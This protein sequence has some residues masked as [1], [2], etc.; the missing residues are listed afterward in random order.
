MTLLPLL[1]P[2]LDAR[3]VETK[4]AAIMK[5]MTLEEKIGQLVQFP[6][7]SA[8]GPEGARVDQNALIAR[9]GMGS[10]LNATGAAA[11][12]ALQR[13]AVENSRLKIPLLFGFDVIHGYRT[14]FPV[15]L[16]L[17][18]TWD[19]DLIERTARAAAVESTAEGVRWTFSPMVDV[20]RDARW[21]RILEG[22]G[23]DTWLGEK[24]AAAYVRGYQGNSL[25]D[26]TSMIAC[27]KHYAAYGGAEAGRDYNT[28]DL[29]DRVLRQTYLPP[30]KAA[31]DAGAATLM[32]SFNALQGIPASADRRLMTDILRKEWGFRGFVVS[33]WNSIGEL[34]PHGV[35]LDAADAA[36]KGLNAGVDMD[37]AANAY[38]SRLVSLV[39]SGR[40]KLS[41]VDEATR[42]VLRVKVAMGL[43]DR[44]YTDESLAGEA[45]L[46]PSH[47]QLARK[48]AEASF[49]LL[50]NEDN[51]LPL[52]AG[53]R[54]ALIGPLAD[55]AADM[56]GG[57]SA[58]GV[59]ADVV[60]LRAALSDR[61]KDRLTYAKGTEIL[62]EREDGF[63]EAINNA[64]NADVV[65]MALGE[66]RD[67]SGEAHSRANLNLP[68]N[69]LA[70]LK[71]V[72]A[73]GKPIVLVLFSGRPLALFWESENVPA[74]L[75]AWFPGVQ[76]GPALA[77]TLFGEATPSGR[78]TASFPRSVGQMPLYYNVLNTGRPVSTDRPARGYVSGY[79]DERTTPQYPFG[80]GLSYTTFAYSTPTILTQRASAKALN[81]GKT[82]I[83]VEATLT[84]TGQKPGTET[85][86]LYINERG[87]SIARPVRELKGYQRVT[88]APGESRRLR[89]T[90]TGD[91][92]AFWNESMKRTVEPC[93]LTLWIAPHA[94]GGTSSAKLRIDP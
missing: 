52:Q 47:V 71:A 12:N 9:G 32:S 4:V 65:V 43:F 51:T 3:A 74:I 45:L 64:K 59:P 91:D 22:A 6:N 33:D 24:V 92:L 17:S 20:A 10:I 67:M 37:M 80:W 38:A 42:R 79:I 62:G 1:A 88:L 39:K 50:K 19:T 48:V 53:K 85:P 46:A 16:G 40:V 56:L 26:P 21:G 13:Q 27:V 78:L 25:T 7:G 44:P 49:V 72:V 11:T 31:L 54:I 86:Q 18:A 82:K 70:L 23:E 8:T 81:A 34:I 30:Y 57:W 5:R 41:T 76:A 83:E 73:T 29:S 15:P 77:R 58:K 75:E 28:V 89:F 93:E 55:S 66:S 90:L 87:T 69:Q 61:L 35:A 84:N 60:T 2:Q 94:Q 68:G 36:A 14:I 63:P